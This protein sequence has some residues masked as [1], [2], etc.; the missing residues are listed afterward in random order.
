MTHVVPSG[1]QEEIL[2]AVGAGYNCIINAVAGSGKTTTTLLLAQRYPKKK[3]LLFTYNA[4]LKAETRQRVKRLGITNLD[5]HSFHSFGLAYYTNPCITDL[6]LQT[7]VKKNLPLN[8]KPHADIVILDETQDMTKPYFDFVHKALMDMNKISSQIVVLGDEMQCIYDFPQKGADLRFLTLADQLW[9]S[10]FPWKRLH[11]KTSYRITKPMEQFINDVV[12]GYPRMV[13]VKKSNTPVT[14]VHGE[15]FS[16]VPL[17]ILNEIRKLL[18]HTAPSDIFIL[19]ASVRSHNELN[20]VKKLE[21]MLVKAGIPVYIPMSDDAE[22]KDEVLEGKVV[23]SSFHQSKG[24]ERKIVFVLNFSDSYFTYYGKDKNRS[25]CPNTLYV[26]VTRAMEKLYVIGQGTKNDRA[27]QFLNMRALYNSHVETID[28][29]PHLEPS[30]DQGSPKDDNRVL[31]RVTDLT[32]FIP[33]QL[34]SQVIEL[35]AMETVTPSYTSIQIPTIISTSGG[36]KEEVSDITGIAIPTI[37]E[38]SLKKTISIQEDLRDFFLRTIDDSATEKSSLKKYVK[39]I[40]KTPSTPADYLLL[41][42]IYAAYVSGLLHKIE[43]ISDYSWV[44]EGIMNQLLTVL[45]GAIGEQ[46]HATEFEY[47]LDEMSYGFHDKDIQVVGR[48]DMIDRNALWEFKC[49]DSLKGEHIVQLAM[50][51]WLWQRTQYN[52]KGS[53][54]FLLH[55]IRT[56]EVLELKGI[57]N[58]NYVAD[59]VFDNH[60]RTVVTFTDE[61]FLEHCKSHTKT[62]SE[63]TISTIKCLFMDD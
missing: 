50:Y 23:F 34:M 10:K 14:Y 3:F 49:V 42:N 35:C 22:L 9:E 56:G 59:M 47:T 16:K 61:Q 54:R 53:R 29:S 21:N 55:N 62:Y 5:V 12:L 1:E 31:R 45:K 63:P 13:A 36:R 44:S 6:D 26:A 2:Q 7:I 40:L 30:K 52:V 20:P 41:S 37:Y 60:F 58:L 32:R 11:L 46:T 57:Q 43:Q 15:Q 33:D 8:G 48:A 27:A 39:E 24:L 4:R 18:Q 28:V 25:I 51:A 38:H 17:Y 19:A